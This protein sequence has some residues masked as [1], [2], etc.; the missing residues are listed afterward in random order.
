M[1]PVLLKLQRYKGN[2]KNLMFLC[3]LGLSTTTLKAEAIPGGYSRVTTSERDVM[4][5]AKFAL[6]A[7]EQAM[8][9]KNPKPTKI[10]FVQVLKA[11]QQVVAGFNYWLDLKV[12]LNGVEKD[13]E[14][15]VWWQPWAEKVQYKLTSWEWKEPKKKNQRFKRRR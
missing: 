1:N 8:Q 3:M 7:Q 4:A 10:E 11:K 15:V 9:A 14:A 2:M 13:A 5:A 12:K 6:N